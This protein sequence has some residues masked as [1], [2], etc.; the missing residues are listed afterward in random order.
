MKPVQTACVFAALL[1]GGCAQMQWVKEDATPEQF[2]ADA[3]H[4]RQEAWH[5]ARFRTWAFGPPVPLVF[6][7]AAGRP[8][9]ARHLGFHDPFNDPFFEESRLAH[10]CLRAKGW[11]L[12]EVPKAAKP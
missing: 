5:E 4:C 7:D 12:E 8:F 1:L 10:F 11:R 3:A 9:I 2:Q 6:R